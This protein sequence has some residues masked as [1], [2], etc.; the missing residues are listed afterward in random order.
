MIGI[1]F[2]GSRWN[3]NSRFWSEWVNEDEQTVAIRDVDKSLVY[4]FPLR[5]HVALILLE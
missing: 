5:F 4:Y 2:D 3:L 1:R